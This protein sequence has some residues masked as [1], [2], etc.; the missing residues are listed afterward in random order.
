MDVRTYRNPGSRPVEVSPKIRKSLLVTEVFTVDAWKNMILWIGV[1]FTM[2]RC[3]PCR[4]TSDSHIKNSVY[5]FYLILFPFWRPRTPIHVRKI[6][7]VVIKLII[8]MD[9]K[10][11]VGTSIVM[12]PGEVG[13]GCGV[14]CWG[15]VCWWGGVMGCGG[16]FFLVLLNFWTLLKMIYND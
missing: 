2:R 16:G 4:G 10:Q 14:G 13:C 7:N 12:S 15:G 8:A 5:T 9:W 1:Y 3:W 11:R 6:P